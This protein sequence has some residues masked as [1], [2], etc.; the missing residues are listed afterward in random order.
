M[1]K[2]RVK[3]FTASQI[4]ELEKLVN[5]WMGAG[6]HLILDMKYQISER[7]YHYILIR[8]YEKSD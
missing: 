1:S 3:I 2:S 4:H 7:A 5:A 8:Y 6:N